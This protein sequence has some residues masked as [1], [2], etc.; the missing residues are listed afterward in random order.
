MAGL[1]RGSKM[2]SEYTREMSNR[3]NLHHISTPHGMDI[4]G[5]L[6]VC[7]SI[8]LQVVPLRQAMGAVE[9]CTT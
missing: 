2:Q 6:Q 4:L 7:S 1:R 8:I 3:S 9:R 5:T